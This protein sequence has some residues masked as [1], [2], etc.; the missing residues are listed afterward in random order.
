MKRPRLPRRP[1]PGNASQDAPDAAITQA[2]H[3]LAAANAEVARVSR[4]RLTQLLGA[5]V[6][7]RFRH[8]DDPDLLPSDRLTLRVSVLEPR[9]GRPS[10]WSRLLAA[11][12]VVSSRALQLPRTIVTTVILSVGALAA[13]SAMTSHDGDLAHVTRIT[14]ITVK[15]QDGSLAR[16]VLGPGVALTVTGDGPTLQAREWIAGAGYRTYPI[17]A[18][19]IDVVH[20][21]PWQAVKAFVAAVHAGWARPAEP[22]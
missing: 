11:A 21:S 9:P 3:D 12:E 7:Q 8:F 14:R 6:R 22:S 5:S 10:L 17:D 15:N 2:R 18:R 1:P 13:L 20:R 16:G 19:D 4:A